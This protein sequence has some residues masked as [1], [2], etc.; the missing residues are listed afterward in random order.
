[1]LWPTLPKTNK[2]G[3]IRVKIAVY[4]FWH[5]YFDEFATFGDTCLPGKILQTSISIPIWRMKNEDNQQKSPNILCIYLSIDVKVWRTIVIFF[6]SNKLS[7][8]NWHGCRIIS[9]CRW[10]LWLMW[11][12]SV[13]AVQQNSEH[14]AVELQTKVRKDFPST[15]C[16]LTPV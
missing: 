14:W 13:T 10:S 9:R 1:M 5:R 16:V 12:G 7:A 15:Y 2:S 11:G 8:P 3:L 6:L 4:R